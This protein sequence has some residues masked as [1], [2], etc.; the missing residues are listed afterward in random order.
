MMDHVWKCCHVGIFTEVLG[1]D[2]AGKLRVISLLVEIPALW[3]VGVGI[4]ESQGPFLEPINHLTGG[5]CLKFCVP[6]PGMLT[7]GTREVICW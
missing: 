5:R 4:F 1:R 2:R 6:R 3:Q 7:K